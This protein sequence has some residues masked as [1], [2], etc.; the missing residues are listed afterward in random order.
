MSSR[1]IFIDNNIA[2]GDWCVVLLDGE[3]IHEGHDYPRG[4]WF[5]EF[6]K[7]YQGIAENV[8]HIQMQDEEIENWR[9]IIYGEEE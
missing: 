9:K 4:A 5:V 1:M 3:V 6:F 8:E 7:A 2:S